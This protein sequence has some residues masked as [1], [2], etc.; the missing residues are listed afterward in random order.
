MKRLSFMA[1]SSVADRDALWPSILCGD[2]SF[3]VL[4]SKISGEARGG[5]AHIDHSVG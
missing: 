3:S 5:K 4:P 1:V 2:G